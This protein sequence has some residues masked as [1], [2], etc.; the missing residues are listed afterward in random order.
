MTPQQQFNQMQQGSVEIPIMRESGQ[1]MQ[2][3]GQ[4]M[5]P[6]FHGAQI[7]QMPQEAAGQ[8]GQRVYP[9]LHQAQPPRGPPQTGQNQQSVPQKTYQASPKVSR[10]VRGN[11]SGNQSPR[12]P[13]RNPNLGPQDQGSANNSRSS[14]P[15]KE[16]TQMEKIDLIRNNVEDLRRDVDE[17]KGGKGDKQYINLEEMLT[18]N[19]LKLDLIDSEGNSD[20]RLARKNVVRSVQQALDQLELKGMTYTPPTESDKIV[21]NT[22]TDASRPLM[23]EQNMQGQQQNS[24]PENNGYAQTP[25]NNANAPS[26]PPSNA[27]GGQSAPP[28]SGQPEPTRVKEMVL[29]S[30][31]AC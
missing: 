16:M 20:I 21:D 29:N 31:V 24:V 15:F 11:R 12:T 27:N 14:T 28:P 26:A 19:M 25:V 8:Q 9:N 30:E 3:H 18:R 1:P 10:D 2:N 23:S 7:H 13:Q 22:Q 5:R 17:F 4:N 6:Q